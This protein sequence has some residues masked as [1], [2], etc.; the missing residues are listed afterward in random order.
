V[1]LHLALEPASAS[2]GRRFVR[3]TATGWDLGVDADQLD[4][5]ELLAS[6]L[7]TNSLV[8][9]RSELEVTADHDQR[10][11]RV[12]VS[13]L[14]SRRPVLFPP[15]DRA[16]GG[17]GLALVDMLADDWGVDDLPDGK[18][19]WFR[20]AVANPTTPADTAGQPQQG[21]GSTRPTS[22]G[23]APSRPAAQGSGAGA[24]AAI[25]PPPEMPLVERGQL[26][27]GVPLILM[28]DVE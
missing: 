12:A 27:D 21:A 17:R 18:A 22:T 13:D 9:A 24:G 1:H 3:D 25:P 2:R 7:I 8:H 15:D 26:K 14:D 5:L 19:V 28:P 10:G 4:V 16:L 23:T 11:V 6:E 20:L